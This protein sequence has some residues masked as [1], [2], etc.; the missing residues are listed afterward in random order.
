V[1]DLQ[2]ATSERLASFYAAMT[3]LERILASLQRQD[4]DLDELTAR[5]LYRRDLDCQNLGAS[6]MLEVIAAE[7][8]ASAEPVRHD[9]LLDVGC[10]LGGP[11]R[12]LVDRYGCVVTGIDLLPARVELARELTRRVRLGSSL[13]YLV[14]DVTG[15]PFADGVF[16]QA[17]MLDVGVHVRGKAAMFGQIARVLRPD[18]LLVMHDQMGPLGRA[19]RPLTRSAPYVAPSLTSIIRTIEAAGLRLVGWRDTTARIVDYFSVIRDRYGPL[20]VG[21]DENMSPWRK[22]V[23][24][25]TAAYLTAL[26]DGG[27]RTGLMLAQRR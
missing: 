26:T 22:W 19:M 21:P 15:L 11:G 6:G 4:V 7:V 10:G 14:A 23:R 16:A 27:G 24:V 18:G 5:D 20:E 13:S 25:T 8:A 9:R 12:F 3:S 17:W 1:T 2:P